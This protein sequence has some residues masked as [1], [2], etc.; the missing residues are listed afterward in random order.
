M[1]KPGGRKKPE[2]SEFFQT[3]TYLDVYCQ[4]SKMYRLA[5][6]VGVRDKEIEINFDGTS[7]KQ[8]EV[9]ILAGGS[10]LFRY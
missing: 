9:S 2:L 5:R 7:K 10:S 6:I 3:G 4:L 1:I 8:N